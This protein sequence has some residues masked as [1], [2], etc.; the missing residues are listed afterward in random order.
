MKHKNFDISITQV[1]DKCRLRK[2]FQ[3]SNDFGAFDHLGKCVI[4]SSKTK[5]FKCLEYILL[6][7]N[8]IYILI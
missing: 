5:N 6:L 3:F 8:N 4:L 2:I 1:K 7:I